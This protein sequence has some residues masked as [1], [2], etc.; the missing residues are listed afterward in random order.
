MID[1]G[2]TDPIA[3]YDHD[4]GISVIGG[5]VYRGS[6]MPWLNG[7]YIFA[8]FGQQFNNDGRLFHLDANNGIQEF[9]IAG[10]GEIDFFILGMGQDA[11]GELYALANNTGVPFDTTGKLVRLTAPVSL[12]VTGSCPGAVTAMASNGTPGGRMAFIRAM[13]T[14]SQRIPQ[15]NPCAGTVLGLNR[16]AVLVASPVANQQGSASISGNVPANACGRVFLQV[17]DVQ[18]CTTSNVIGL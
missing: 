8:E 9:R 7:T 1:P 11:N 15:G 12:S 6:A 14:G 13:G 5:F 4:E 18:T 16:T 10:G 17:L 3:Q 2:L